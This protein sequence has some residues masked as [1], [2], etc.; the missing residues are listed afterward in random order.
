MGSICSKTS[1]Y[2]FVVQLDEEIGKSTDTSKSVSSI[3]NDST[4]K[5]KGFISNN[6]EIKNIS[7]INVELIEMTPEVC[8]PLY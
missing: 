8:K 2:D 5:S 4:S 6:E 3:K 1:N 7:T